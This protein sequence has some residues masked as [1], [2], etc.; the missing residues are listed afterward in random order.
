MH[1][2][3]SIILPLAAFIGACLALFGGGLFL[4]SLSL[5]S[6]ARH[7][8]RL[9][10]VTRRR[11]AGQLD[12]DDA[13]LQNIRRHEESGPLVRAMEVVARLVPML[14]A[15]KLRVDIRR[16]GLKLS[17]ASV[18]ALA[19]AGGMLLAL[20]ASYV[21]DLSLVLAMPLGLVGGMFA[22][23]AFLRLRG[24]MMAER[25]MKQLPPALDTIIRGVRAG[26]PVLE[27][28]ANIGKEFDEP[29]GSHFQI[30]SERVQLGEPLD[31]AIWRSAEV[32]DRS[33]MDFLAVCI[34]IQMETGGS[35]AEALGNL[36]SLLRARE[37]MKLKV[38]AISSEA[39]MSA[40]IIGALPFVMVLLLAVMSPDYISPLFTDPRGQFMLFCGLGSISVGAFV[41]W[42]MTRFEI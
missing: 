4:L 23:N 16:S 13:L 33:E 11:I 7:R 6:Q 15:A 18:A 10:R 5:K 19:V 21:M 26:L 12:R 42:R 14:D 36:A 29:I 28:I 9:A 25:F 30:I 41:M 32:I 34:S 17:V 35:L 2:G 1:G 22:V 40:V 27:G 8:R 3:L 20:I 37:T 38:R 24:E 31:V 39:R